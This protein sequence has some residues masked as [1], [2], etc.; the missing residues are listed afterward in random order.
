MGGG[1]D[2]DQTIAGRTSTPAIEI[3][4]AVRQDFSRVFFIIFLR[5]EYIFTIKFI[6]NLIIQTPYALSNVRARKVEVGHKLVDKG[7]GMSQ[8][9]THFYSD[10]R[11]WSEKESL[12]IQNGQWVRGILSSCRMSEHLELI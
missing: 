1:D 10:S 6:F 2:G 4:A 5:I 11:G 9:Q 3:N 8:K 7:E 12:P